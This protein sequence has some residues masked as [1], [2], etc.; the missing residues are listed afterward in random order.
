MGADLYRRIQNGDI[1]GSKRETTTAVILRSSAHFAPSVSK[2][3]H[4]HRVYFHPS[5]PALRALLRMTASF[6]SRA[7]KM[8]KGSARLR[9]PSDY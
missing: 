4:T 1:C 2:D 9:S 8:R 7:R 6:V 5:R 3:G